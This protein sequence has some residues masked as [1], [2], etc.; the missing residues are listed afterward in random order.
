M[1]VLAVLAFG[2][3][4]LKLHVLSPREHFHGGDGVAVAAATFMI[5]GLLTFGILDVYYFAHDFKKNI[6]RELGERADEIKAMFAAEANA[7]QAEL[8]MRADARKQQL[9]PNAAF[10]NWISKKSSESQIN[11]HNDKLACTPAW[12]CGT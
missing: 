10:Q 5:A 1:G 12:V 11:F 3:P 4:L 8:D 6:D 9:A 2:I 7:A